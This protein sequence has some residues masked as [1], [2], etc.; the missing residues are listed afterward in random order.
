M[1]NPFKF[2]GIVEAPAF[3]NRQNE[4]RE[5]K[6][7]IENSQNV[8]LYSH[9]RYGK[10][11]LIFKIFKG[12]KNI[13]P[14]YIDLYGTTRTEEFITSFLKGVSTVESQIDRLMKIIREGIRSIGVNFTVDPAT[15][16]PTASPVFNRAAEGRTIDEL[17]SFIQRLSKKKKMVVAFDEF[18]EVSTYGGDAFEKNLRRS[19]QL[20]DRVAYIF[21]GS[22]RHLLTDMFNDRKRAF[23][24]LATSY[25]LGKIDNAEY[26]SW[27]KDL[28]QRARKRIED[29]FIEEVVD[30]CEN[31][32][33]YVQEF[34][35]NIWMHENISYENLDKIE[36]S[37]VEKRVAEYSYAW[38]AL[39]LNQKR[40]L[41]LIAGTAGK[42]IFAAENLDRYGF[43][44]AS[45]VTAAL[46][47]I[48]KMGIVDKNKEWKIH[49]P[50]FKRWL[51]LGS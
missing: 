3:C 11:S 14:V 31:H 39:T 17:F 32:P 30:R 45:Q 47:S 44:T 24:M 10:S 36:R 16:M 13:T 21:S 6:Q 38:D 51:L 9:R 15:G 48:E 29:K 49:D 33:M 5:I 28:Y 35:F 50:F 8:L 4:Q 26:K 27:I 46:K 7:Y 19:I 41:K 42:Y 1:E 12:L 2:S 18:Q 22:Q 23:Y 43:R 20:H 25:P 34:F 40:S 37:I